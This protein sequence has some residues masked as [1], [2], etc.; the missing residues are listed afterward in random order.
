MYLLSLLFFNVSD[1]DALKILDSCAC[2][3]SFGFCFIDA[4]SSFIFSK[5]FNCTKLLFRLLFS[6]GLSLGMNSPIW[7]GGG[8]WPSSYYTAH[9]L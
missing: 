1:F 8:K 9:L 7:G 4:D 2:L 6:L 5:T 3:V